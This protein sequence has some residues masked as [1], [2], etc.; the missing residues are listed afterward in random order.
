[1]PLASDTPLDKVPVGGALVV[2]TTRLH[3]FDTFA[4]AAKGGWAIT[5]P[6]GSGTVYIGHAATEITTGFPI[7]AGAILTIDTPTLRGWYVIA[8]G[9]TEIRVIGAKVGS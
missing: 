4:D 8:A 2:D 1:M 5:V 9:A 3:L 6:I 7:A